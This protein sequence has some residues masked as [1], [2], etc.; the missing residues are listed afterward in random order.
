MPL[1]DMDERFSSKVMQVPDGCWLWTGTTDSSGYGQYKHLGRS[2][3]AHR[4]VYEQLVGDIPEGLEID[5]LCRVRSCVNP[6][7]MDPVTYSENQRRGIGNLNKTHCKRG[8]ND[9][10]PQRSGRRCRT[11]HNEE[12]RIRYQRAKELVCLT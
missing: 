9:W 1:V 6:T 10:V 3:I 7:H 4:Y 11:C 2:R 5:H 12:S 8:H